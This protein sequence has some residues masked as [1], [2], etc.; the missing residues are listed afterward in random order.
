MAV[1]LGAFV[2]DTAARWRGVAKGEVA[3]ELG[4]AAV[5]SKLAARLERVAALVDDAEARAARRDEDA[6]E[7]LATVRATAYE[8][9]GAVDRFKVAGRRYRDRE[10]QQQ[11]QARFLPLSSNKALPWL[12]SS[13]CENDAEPRREVAAEIKNVSKKLKAVLKEQRRLQLKASSAADRTVQTRAVLR[14]RNHHDVVG[15][16]IQDDTRQLVDRLTQTQGRAACE[17]VAI[18]G[19]D[20]I[21]KTTLAKA[22]YDSARV[23][24]IFEIRSW[25]R[26]RRGYTEA[27]LLS[28][29]VDAV[30][31]DT[32][33]DESVADLEAMLAGLV[34]NK[35]F[36]LVVDDVWY[37]GVWEDALRSRLERGGRGSKVL[38]TARSGSIARAMDASNVHR[39]NRLGADDGWQLLRVAACVADEEGD[40]GRLKGL[41]ERF[42][43]K[44]GGVPLAIEVIAGVLRTREASASEWEEVLGSPAWL[45]KGLPDNAMTPLYLCYDDLP[46]H[47]KQCLLY[48]SLFPPGFAV[49]RRALVQQWV[50]ERFVQ[51]RVGATVEEVAEEYYHELVGRNLLQ[52]TEED[53]HS[54]GTE[55][56]TMHEMLHALAQLLLQGEGF[57]G[58]AQRPLD[59]GDGSFA[60]RRVS[61]PGRNMAAVPDWVLNSDRIRTL[62]LPKNPL[63]TAGKILERMHHL[64]VLDLSETGLELV[65][66]TLGN[67]V[68]LRFLNLSRTRIHA[69]PESIGN[70]TSDEPQ[71]LAAQRVQVTACSAQKHRASERTQ[72][73]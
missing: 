30:G 4:V 39:V 60:L 5:A 46:C 71:V 55:R 38:I 10:P 52:T 9:D 47:L 23:R 68:H 13:C 11:Q 58:N 31:G 7:W 59:D 72:R 35:R 43:E 53:A 65:P 45:L 25:V 28:Q 27:G 51:A 48:C 34:A 70:L 22:V 8:C 54:G 16:R 18:I 62:L 67:L 41:G 37:G 63:A 3:R 29:V 56:C 42:V 26:L 19:P 33:G 12:L 50:A 69:V 64:R 32:A 57:T 36:L 44:C 20:G 15:K 61:L 21:G 49:D 2:P 40:A 1:V 17:V 66:E 24:C 73:P 14:R 6:A